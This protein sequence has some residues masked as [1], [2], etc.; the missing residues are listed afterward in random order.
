MLRP[1]PGNAATAARIAALGLTALRLPLFAV[2]ALPWSVPDIGRYDALLLTSAN[3]VRFGGNGLDALKPLPVHAV[4]ATTASAASDAGFVIAQTGSGSAA[5]LRLPYR[6]L[7]L[8]GREHRSLPDVDVV[9][10]YAS[11]ALSPDLRSLIGA[12]AMVHSP[13]AAARLAAMVGDRGTTRIAAISGAAAEAAG[14]GWAA[15]SVADVPTDDAL[16]AVAR[17]LAD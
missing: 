11:D 10:V 4:G 9:P 16:I 3:A 15:I 8:A 12:V 13:R 2:R 6:T 17:R 14:A 5:D 7:H 1:E